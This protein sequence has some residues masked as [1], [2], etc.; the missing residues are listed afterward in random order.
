MHVNS[1]IRGSEPWW[2]RTACFTHHVCQGL[3]RGSKNWTKHDWASCYVPSVKSLEGESERTPT[4]RILTRVHES[5]EMLIHF[6]L[7][8]R[9]PTSNPSSGQVEISSALT[10]WCGFLWERCYSSGCFSSAVLANADIQQSLN[11]L[12][13]SNRFEGWPEAARWI[14]C[15]KFFFSFFIESISVWLCK[16]P[17]VTKKAINGNPVP[18]V[19][20]SDIELGPISYPSK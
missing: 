12:R 6:F 8:R 5:P 11:A 10:I 20:V 17:A 14:N 4:S 2:W 3:L 9:S 13:A 7:C 18:P 19:E 15:P 1:W 16:H